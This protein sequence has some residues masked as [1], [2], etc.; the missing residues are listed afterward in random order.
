MYGDFTLN[1]FLYRDDVS[2][3]LLQQGRV[4]L[5]S[6]FNEHTEAVLRA[7][8]T[9]IRDIIGPH[10]GYQNSFRISLFNGNEIRI[11]NGHYYV[12]GIRVAN[13]DTGNRLNRVVI[14]TDTNPN[15]NLQLGMLYHQQPNYPGAKIADF[16]LKKTQ[17]VYLDV[18]ERHVSAAEDDSLREVALLGPDTASRAVIVWQVKLL[19]VTGFG[20]GLDPYEMLRMALHPAGRL[21]A[22]AHMNEETEACIISPEA[23][24]RGAVNRLYRVEVHKIDKDNGDTYV[25]WSPDN[26]SIVYP[27]R[28]VQGTTITLDSI[29]RDDRTAIQIGDWVELVDEDVALQVPGSAHDLVQV[30]GVKA[31]RLEIAVKSAPTNTIDTAR[32]RRAVLRRWATKPI[33][34]NF[35][36]G[37]NE[38]PYIDLTDGVSVQLERDPQRR[39]FREGDYWLIPA[40]TATGDIIWPRENEDY[41]YVAPHGVQHHYAPLAQWNGTTFQDLRKTYKPLS[42]L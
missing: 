8:R 6:D 38:T 15:T 35:P 31:S 4:Q 3:V 33:K 27:V 25:K 29:G 24:Y 41:A 37:M 32:N 10:A 39:S 13:G 21:R 28:D 17:L 14:T 19:D 18:W 7:M 1:P 26:A 22:R 2:R 9:S 34:L 36:Q 42:E 5:D 23:Q 30:L 20:S 12:D 16:D 40:R 11:D